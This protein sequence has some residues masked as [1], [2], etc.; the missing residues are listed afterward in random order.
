VLNNKNK[1]IFYLQMHN[2]INITFS[3]CWYSLKAKFGFN[4]YD[5][6][7][8]KLLSNVKCFNLVI[9][10]DE[11]GEALCKFTTYAASNHRIRVI[12]KPFESLHNYKLKNTWIQNHVNNSIRH[13]VDW[14]VNALWS[15]KVHFVEETVNR[16]YFDTDYYGWCDIGYFRSGPDHI[17]PTML[18][19][20]PNP[21]KIKELNP[22]KI[23]YAS[24]NNNPTQ[25][26][27][28]IQI[29]NSQKLLDPRINYIAGGFFILHKSNAE[30]WKT[31]YQSQLLNQ[32]SLG[33]V[34]KDDQ[35]IITNCVY[36][37]DMHSKFKIC[38]EKTP[39]MLREMNWFLFQFILL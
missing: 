17:D 12:I 30:W 8:K 9:Y 11:E 38:T 23:Y 37:K 39:G 5:V 15:E 31:T 33:Y 27:N 24:V 16:K 25:I 14:R 19:R 4:N 6:W 35:Q 20:W 2:N 32:F 7:I 13:L 28:C 21:E 34:V 3:T 18:E 10:T 36:S 1:Y 26:K 22:E 29:V